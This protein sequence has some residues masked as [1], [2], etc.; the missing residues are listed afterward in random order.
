MRRRAKPLDLPPASRALYYLMVAILHALSLI[1]DFIL[2]PIGVAGGFIGYLLDR[3]HI[4]IGLTNLALAFPDRPLAERRRILRASYVNLGRAGAEYVRLGGFFYRRLK[5]RVAYERFDYWRE[6]QARN[7]GLGIL[8]LTAHFGNFE[9]LPAAHAMHGHQISLVH[10]TQRFF[11][12]DA[13]ATFVRERA[14]VEIIRKHSAAR[15][16]LGALRLA[17]WSEFRLIRTPS[18]VR[19]CSCRSSVS[20]PPLPAGLAR[21]A[22]ISRAPVVPV[23]LSGNPAIGPIAS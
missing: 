20:P 2:Y 17:T 21:L 4:K 12:G 3:R 6:L 10:H 22:L 11:A 5:R 23:F 13:L 7:P 8:V 1:P 14:G 19:R 15:A 16:V 18:A 9:L